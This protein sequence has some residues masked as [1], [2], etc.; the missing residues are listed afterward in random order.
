MNLAE[1]PTVR[2]FRETEGERPGPAEPRKPLDAAWLR[3]LCLDCG[4]DGAGLV[5]VGRPALDGQRG[6]LLRAFPPRPSPP[7]RPWPTSGPTSCGP[8]RTPSRSSASSAG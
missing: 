3:Q 1:H 4:A 7:A 5:E 8:S 6:G 2:R